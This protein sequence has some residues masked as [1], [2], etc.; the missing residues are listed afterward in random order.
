MK[1][2][3]CYLLIKIHRLSPIV[4][5]YLYS[6]EDY[7]ID[8]L[9]DSRPSAR[10]I[11]IDLLIHSHWSELLPEADC[12]QAPGEP[13]LELICILSSYDAE[14]LTEVLYSDQQIYLKISCKINAAEVKIGIK[15]VVVH[16]V[17][18]MLY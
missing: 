4:E 17:L 12:L 3:M 7:R 13:V 10:S 5:E 11:Q 14:T 9:I 15:G 8:I 2:M 18:L 16:P 6:M 1:R